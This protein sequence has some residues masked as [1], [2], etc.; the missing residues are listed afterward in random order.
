MKQYK[1]VNT[2]QKEKTLCLEIAIDTKLWKETQQKQTQDLTKN[3]KIKGFRKGKVPPTLAKDY[4]DRAEL[5]QRS[6]QAVIDAIF[7]PLQQEAVIADNENV[8][9]DF[10][11]I[12]FKTINENDC[13]ILFDFDLVPQF[14]LP[15]YKHIKD[16]SPIVPLKDEEFNKELHNIEKNKGKLVDVSDKALANNDIAVIDFVGK[17]DGKVLESATAKQYELTIGSNSFI[18]GFESGLIGMKV[19][20]KRQLKLKFPKD[21][22]AE[23]LKG[24]PVEFD[25]ELK[26]IKQLEITPMDETNFKEYLPA[27]YQGFNSLKEFKT[28]FHKLVSAKKLE[29]TLQENSV[30][31]RQ[32]F[33]AN[34]TLPYIPDSLIKLESDRLLRA[35]KDQAEQYKIPFERLLAASKLSLEQ[36]QQR[37]I[38]EARDNVTFAL[39]MK[40]IADVEKIKVDNKKI[41]SEIESIIDVEYPFVN[42]ELKKQMF[43]NMEQQKDFVESIILNRLTTTKIIEYSTH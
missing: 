38:K 20:D 10:P 41:H 6:A 19:G 1:L 27:Q 26:A 16:L 14:E 31:I 24:K 28:Y 2:T 22:H 34:T 7:Q 4:L 36:L 3:M 30:K 43:H 42:A 39:V 37:N 17:V 25:I 33:L 23:E 35:Q 12:D 29:I 9:E 21:Y 40:R 32:F 13:V 5:L 11:T 8:I 18:D 15:D